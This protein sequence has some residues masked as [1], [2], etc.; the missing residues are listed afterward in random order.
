MRESMHM[1]PTWP[2]RAQGLRAAMLASVS[3]YASCRCAHMCA[4]RAGELLLVLLLHFCK[5]RYRGVVE[6]VGRGNRK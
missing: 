5:Y 1:A 3:T 2:R 6:P 4:L